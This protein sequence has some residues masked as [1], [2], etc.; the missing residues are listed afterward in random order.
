MGAKKSVSVFSG[1]LLCGS[2]KEKRHARARRNNSLKYH[3][4]LNGEKVQACKGFFL[5][6]IGMGEWSL[7]KWALKGSNDN[8]ITPKKNQ[9]NPPQSTTHTTE[10]LRLFFDMLPKMKSHYCRANSQKKYLEP[11]FRSLSEVYGTYRKY[12]TENNVE[13]AS[14]LKLRTYFKMEKYSIYSPKKDQ[15][16]ICTSYNITEEEYKQHILLKTEGRLEKNRDNE[17]ALNDE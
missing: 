12:C 10:S 16:D 13:T 11:V 4:V 5:G 6:T 1:I 2:K 3:L 14:I 17:I 7:R 9:E 15:C 8:N